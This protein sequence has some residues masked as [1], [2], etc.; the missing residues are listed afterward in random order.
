LSHYGVNLRSRRGERRY[1]GCKVLKNAFNERAKRNGNK[2]YVKTLGSLLEYP[3]KHIVY[4]R[5]KFK[6]VYY[7]YMEKEFTNF[8]TKI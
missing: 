3:R 6:R 8:A 4:W 2:R 7:L 5:G 1:I